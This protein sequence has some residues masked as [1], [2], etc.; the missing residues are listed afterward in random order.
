MFM[1]E[2]VKNEL[3]FYDQPDSYEVPVNIKSQFV[4]ALVIQVEQLCTLFY[5]SY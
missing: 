2:C 4:K 1:A 3:D 5:L